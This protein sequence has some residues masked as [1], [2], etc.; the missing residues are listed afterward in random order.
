MVVVRQVPTQDANQPGF[1][2]D[3]QMIEALSSDGADEP[4]RVCVLPWRTRGGAEFLDA[5]AAR[6][7]R[8]RGKRVVAIVNEVARSRLFGKRLAQWLGGPRRGRMRGD[9]DVCDALTLVIQKRANA[10]LV[11]SCC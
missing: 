7:G 6:R 10:T 11:S 8:E 9:R 3:D 4:L 2:H 1:M 5:H